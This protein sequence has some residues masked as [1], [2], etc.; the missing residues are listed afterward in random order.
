MLA[1]IEAA[2]QPVASSPKATYDAQG[3]RDPFVPLVKDGKLIGGKTEGS[4]PELGGILWDPENPIAMIGDR[5]L[6]VGDAFDDYKVVE[7]RESSVILEDSEGARFEIK[8]TAF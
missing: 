7:I 4:L 5:E 6:T 3:K 2:E 1:P 8:Q